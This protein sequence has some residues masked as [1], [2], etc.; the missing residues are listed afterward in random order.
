MDN[1]LF[2]LIPLTIISSIGNA[3]VNKDRKYLK[4]VG[5]ILFDKEIDDAA[6]NNPDTLIIFSK[7][8]YEGEKPAIVK[9]FK[10]KYKNIRNET[11]YIVI[12]FFVNNEGR[13]G[14]F[15]VQEMDFELQKKEFDPRVSTQ[16]LNL[17][18]ELKGWKSIEYLHKFY[19][20]YTYLNFKIVNGELKEV[21]P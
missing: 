3:Q 19:G 20:Y 9:H 11:G 5:Q 14:K 18:K 4:E 1:L 2:A 12:H 8:K 15:R 13:T 6:F 17:T 21:T 7:P 16:I 10:E